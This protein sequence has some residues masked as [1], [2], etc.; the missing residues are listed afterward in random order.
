MKL[1]AVL[2]MNDA[3]MPPTLC[4]DVVELNRGGILLYRM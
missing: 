3:E 2:S 1:G 4:G